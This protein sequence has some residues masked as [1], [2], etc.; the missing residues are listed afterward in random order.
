MSRA[1]AFAAGLALAGALLAAPPAA[2]ALDLGRADVAAFV[3]EVVERD[4]L[5]RAYVERVLGAAEIKPAIVDI[6]TRPAEHVRPWYQYEAVF[7]TERR[8]REGREFVAAHAAELAAATARYGVPAEIVAAIIGVETS[9]GRIMGSYRVVDALATLAFAY[10]PRAPYF[11]GE[12][13]QFLL[14]AREA[15]FDPLQANGSYAGAMGASQFMPRSYRSFAVDGDEDGSIDLWRSWPDIIASTA[16]YF[17]KFGWHPGEAVVAPADLWDPDI[18]GLPAGRLELGA[19][20]AELRARGVL[21]DSP[22]GEDAPAMFIALRAAD[23][24]VYRVGFH[25]FWVITRYNHSSMYALAVSELAAA[26]GAPAS[27][28]DAPDA[29]P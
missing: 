19:R 16:H 23:A 10:P 27:A 17:A 25:N 11:R 7:L 24:P 15:K 22:L 1:R 28:P 6:M 14:L 26:I 12:L 3:T 21:F 2:R 8:I 29:A 4:H 13:E 20:V 9:F 5:E 18:E